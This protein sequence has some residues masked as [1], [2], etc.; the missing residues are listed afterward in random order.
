L[1]S[2]PHENADHLGWD[3]NRLDQAVLEQEAEEVAERLAKS[4]RN[5]SLVFMVGSD[6]RTTAILAQAMNRQLSA[7]ASP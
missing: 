6:R 7:S 1:I 2:F 5:G 4:E 3:E